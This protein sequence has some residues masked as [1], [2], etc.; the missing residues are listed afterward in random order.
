MTR[1]WTRL[2]LALLLGWSVG[3]HPAEVQSEDLFDLSLEELELL[4]VSAQRRTESAQEVP[5]ALS[6][7]S[8]RALR[9]FGVTDTQSLQNVT[10]GLTYNNTG[11]SAQ[12]YLRGVGTRFAF[13]GVEPSVST[14]LDDRYIAR[15]QATIFEFA[16]VERVEVLKGPQGTLYGRNATGGAIRVITLD[17]EEELSGTIT[18]GLGDYDLRVLSGTVNVPFTSAFGGRF[19]ALIKQR[20]G[21]A[22]NLVQTGVSELDDQDYQAFRAKFRWDV[23]NRATSRLTLQYTDRED[24]VGNDIVDLS[25][26]GLNIAGEFEALRKE[27]LKN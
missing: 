5:V 24:N 18:A 25:P 20:D 8:A 14:Y 9:D 26:P 12:P 6:A 13:A 27:L 17:V 22:D 4:V 3:A 1:Q 21:Y 2:L 15:A 11:S 23:S 10:P 19:S 7:F 16:D